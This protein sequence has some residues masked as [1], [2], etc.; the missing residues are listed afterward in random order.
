MD[1]NICQNQVKT[2]VQLVSYV[3]EIVQLLDQSPKL[4]TQQGDIFF[5][6][7][8]SYKRQ[9]INGYPYSKATI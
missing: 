1:R 2:A 6:F 8:W 7:L 9:A 5:L 4:Y 3:V